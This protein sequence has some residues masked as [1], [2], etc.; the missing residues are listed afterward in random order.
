[1]MLCLDNG[2]KKLEVENKEDPIAEII[3]AMNL[4]I[5]ATDMTTYQIIIHTIRVMLM[6]MVYE[7]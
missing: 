5:V 2:K 7:N 4:F 1:M 3:H 6:L